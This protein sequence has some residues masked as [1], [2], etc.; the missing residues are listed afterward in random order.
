M[1]YGEYDVSATFNVANLILF[2]I[3]FDSRLNPFE[4]IGDDIVWCKPRDHMVT[5]PTIKIEIW[6]QKAEIGLIGVWHNGNQPQ[7]TNTIGLSFRMTPR[8]QL[9]FDKSNSVRSRTEECKNHSHVKTE[10][11]RSNYH[12]SCWNL[13]YMYLNNS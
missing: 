6:S 13:G 1:E 9:I 2:N 12:Q 4:E 10:K 3:G 5:Q 7:G 11:F 8:S